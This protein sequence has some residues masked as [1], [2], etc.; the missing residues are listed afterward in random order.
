ML[1][2]ER[3]TQPARFGFSRHPISFPTRTSCQ[4]HGGTNNRPAYFRRQTT[5]FL[6]KVAAQIFAAIFFICV[7]T[8]L[9]YGHNSL[10]YPFA[11]T[12]YNVDSAVVSD[13]NVVT[14]EDYRNGM[15]YS[16]VSVV[17]LTITGVIGAKVIEVRACCASVLCPPRFLASAVRVLSCLSSSLLP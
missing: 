3:Q 15:I 9:R 2:K 11:P 12:S 6:Y 13:R 1:S 10:Y 14:Y 7:V 5:F 8:G 17:F 16:A 4:D